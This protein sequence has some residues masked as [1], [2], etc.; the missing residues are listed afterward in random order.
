MSLILEAL[1]KSEAERRLGQAPD[2]LAPPPPASPR[3]RRRPWRVLVSVAVLAGVAVAAWWLGQRQA[4]S[5]AVTQA[6]ASTEASATG[7]PPRATATPAPIT[8]PAIADRRPAPPPTA[9][10]DQTPPPRAQ[11]QEAPA[12]ATATQP[13][14]AGPA[15]EAE[16]AA[17]RARLEQAAVADPGTRAAPAAP[18]P[19]APIED[20]PLPIGLLSASERA[21]LPPL[22][23]TMHVYND[24]PEQ[25]FVILDGQRRA[26]GA[27][28]A[29]G[30]RLAAIRR[31]GIV[32]DPGTRLIL[33]PRP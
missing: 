6:P 12:P 14:V 27:L 11:V 33:V 18:A 15:S 8:A 22:R 16:L 17:L 31:D 23:L 24:I 9:P 4:G 29:D 20:A 26:E 25:R 13:A 32:I 21:A 2:L 3:R 1:R 30:I 28:I 10:R 5:P 19:A 7:E